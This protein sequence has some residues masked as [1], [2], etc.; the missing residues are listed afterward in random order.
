MQIQ[1]EQFKVAQAALENV[2]EQGAPIS[3]F[4]TFQYNYDDDFVDNLVDWGGVKDDC[5]TIKMEAGDKFH[6]EDPGLE[7]ASLATAQALSFKDTEKSSSLLKR[8]VG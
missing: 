1:T 8:M 5:V 7:E 6:F 3:Q 4:L 2:M